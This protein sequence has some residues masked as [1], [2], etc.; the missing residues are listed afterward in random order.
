MCMSITLPKAFFF[1]I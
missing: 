1:F